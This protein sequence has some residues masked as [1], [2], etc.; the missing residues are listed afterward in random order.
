MSVQVTPLLSIVGFQFDVGWTTLYPLQSRECLYKVAWPGYTRVK[1]SIDVCWTF[2]YLPHPTPEQRTPL[3]S[4]L[5]GWHP[6]KNQNRCCWRFRCRY[7]FGYRFR[8]VSDFFFGFPSV[9]SM[10]FPQ[11]LSVPVN[12]IYTTHHWYYNDGCLQGNSRYS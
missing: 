12:F 6:L 9:R 10:T 8:L 7:L 3:Y 11:N 5:P 4:S 2:L 1:N